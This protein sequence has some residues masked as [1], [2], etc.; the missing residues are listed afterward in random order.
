MSAIQRACRIA[1]L[2]SALV[3]FGELKGAEFN[4]AIQKA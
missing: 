2:P 4:S 1:D 3:F